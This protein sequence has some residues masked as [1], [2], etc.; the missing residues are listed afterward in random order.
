MSRRGIVTAGGV[1]NLADVGECAFLI[2]R[3]LL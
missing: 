2:H 3:A 1:N